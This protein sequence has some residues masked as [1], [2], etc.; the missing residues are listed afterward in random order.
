MENIYRAAEKYAKSYKEA[1][2]EIEPLLAKHFTTSQEVMIALANALSA[3]IEVYPDVRLSV[4]IVS[5]LT[6]TC[7]DATLRMAYLHNPVGN[8]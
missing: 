4:A 6:D 3:C 1:M 2:D 7:N 5:A 8:A